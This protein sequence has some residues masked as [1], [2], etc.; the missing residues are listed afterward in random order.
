MPGLSGHL[1]ELSGRMEGSTLAKLSRE[2][3]AVSNRVAQV[4]PERSPETG[5]R[6]SPG[7]RGRRK[8][9]D[10][11]AD[12]AAD[13]G[14]AGGEV[15]DPVL[16]DPVLADPELADPVLA[17][18]TL[19]GQHADASRPVVAVTG[20][21]AGL[22]LALTRRLAQSPLVG[23]VVALDSH[24]GDVS[25]V[26]WRIVDVRDPALAGRLSDVDVVVHTDVDF[27]PDSD[28]RAGELSTCAAPR[29]C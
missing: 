13:G 11:P 2:R 15:A 27:S 8:P 25:G 23:R 29:R 5:S 22:G 17:E 19:E 10:A 3:P 24:R 9:G 18:S 20:A 1:P 16:A 28:R 7:S 21:A 4:R 6:V 12:V 26:T 14:L